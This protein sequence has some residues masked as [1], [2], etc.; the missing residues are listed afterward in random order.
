ML[1]QT[2]VTIVLSYELLF[3]ETSLLTRDMQEMVIL[4]MLLLVGFLIAL[5]V[6]IVEA[7][8]FTA[9]L[10]LMDTGI[11]SGIIYLS[12][13]ASSDLYLA[14][15]IIILLA[16]TTRS[17]KQMLTLSAVL[18]VAYGGLLYF[19]TFQSSVLSEG[20]LIR[21]PL[22]LVMAI[23]YGITTEAARR[24]NREKT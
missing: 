10:A 12:G 6:K 9:G 3:S 8:W 20:H 7:G 23:F 21:I 24:A 17:L 18:Y 1:L 19:E 2:L 11:T 15:F 5:P 13:N 14:Y 16:A 22:L 4:A